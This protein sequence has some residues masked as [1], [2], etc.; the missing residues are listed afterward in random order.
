VVTNLILHHGIA[1]ILDHVTERVYVFGIGEE[2]RNRASL[3]QRVEVLEDFIE[4]AIDKFMS[5]WRSI[6]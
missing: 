5:A 2:T 4:F 1:D 6:L 3:C